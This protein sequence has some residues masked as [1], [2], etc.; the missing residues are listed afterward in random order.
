MCRLVTLELRALRRTL[1]LQE[2]SS[3]IRESVSIVCFGIQISH[4]AVFCRLTIFY[5]FYILVEVPS[6]EVFRRVGSMWLAFLV[7]AFGVV[8]IATA[9]IH[10]LA[11]V[12]VTRIVLGLAEGGGKYLD[13]DHLVD[14]EGD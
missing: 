11:G 4:S 3:T 5:I 6:N 14:A 13:K 7:I 2:I 1:V 8:S 12:I 10:N 9:F